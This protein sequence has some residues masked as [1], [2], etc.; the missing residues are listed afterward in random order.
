VGV[1]TINMSRLGYTSKDETKFF[2]KLEDLMKL[3]KDSLEIKRKIVTQNINKGLLPFTKRYLGSLKWHFSTVGLIGMNEA[4]LN[5]LGESIASKEG[6]AFA[7]KTL[8]FMRDKLLEFQKET[9]N[10]YNLEATPAEGTSYTLALLDKKKYPKIITAGKKIPYYTNSTFLPVNFT[11]DILEALTHQEDLQVLYTGGTIFH[12]FIGERI[13]DSE[14]CKVLVK[15]I[16]E[17]FRIPYFTIT[18]TFS[19]CSNH[20]Y[21]IGEFNKCPQCSKPTE[22]YSRIVGYYRPVQNWNTG[23]KEEFR[24]RKVYKANIHK[25]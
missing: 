1:V 15:K 17:N 6:K 4:C 9:G 13:N 3:A 25:T 7:V 16:A 19:I 11:D 10:I 18:P 21:I 8:K 14:T 20:G 12:T 5:F 22:V 23:K 24:Q 2:E